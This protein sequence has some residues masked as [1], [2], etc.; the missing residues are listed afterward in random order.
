MQNHNLHAE[1][2]DIPT[3]NKKQMIRNL[4]IE[5]LSTLTG[6]ILKFS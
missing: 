5:V 6:S 4:I 1:A 2:T 3:K